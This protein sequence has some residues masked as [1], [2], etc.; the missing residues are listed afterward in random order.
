MND[1]EVEMVGF[2][3]VSEVD[4]FAF[5]FSLRGDVALELVAGRVHEIFLIENGIGVENKVSGIG[6]FNII[7]GEDVSALNSSS[8]VF[9]RTVASASVNLAVAPPAY[10][11]SS[12]R[13]PPTRPIAPPTPPV[14]PALRSP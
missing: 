14:P 8:W 13:P 7:A 12:S 3:G 2:N 10:S 9:T 5:L 1:I 4:K 11:P 6:Q